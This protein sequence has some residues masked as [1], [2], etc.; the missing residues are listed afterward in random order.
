MPPLRRPLRQGRVPGRVR[1]ARVPVR[2][3]LRGVRP[4][5]HGLPDEGLRRSRSTSTCCARPSRGAAAS[6]RC[7]RPRRRCRCA[8][9]R[10]R[11]AT[12]AG[13]TSSAASTPSSTS[14]RSASRRSGF[15]RR[16]LRSLRVELLAASPSAPRPG[17]GRRPGNLEQRGQALQLRVAEEDAELLADQA[18]AD[19]LVPVAVRAERRLRVVHVQAAQ[20]VEADLAVELARPRGRARPASV[21]S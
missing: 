21:T 2:L 3:L 20:A 12:R 11:A 17:R 10:S 7:G 1:R 14:C 19:V 9:S 5:V 6:A 4:H 18:V 16:S 13:R 8:G 15:S